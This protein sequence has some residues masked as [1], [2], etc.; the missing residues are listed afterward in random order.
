MRPAPPLN[1]GATLR[2][3]RSLGLLCGSL[4][5]SPAQ[6]AQAE[7]WA[8]DA[9]ERT[10]TGTGTGHGTVRATV[11]EAL[12]LEALR[13]QGSGADQR[14]RYLHAGHGLLDRFW[15]PRQP[16]TLLLAGERA[17]GCGAPLLRHPLAF[18]CPESREIGL[19]LDLR[20]SVRAARGRSDQELLLLELTVLAHEWGHHINRERG[21]GPYRA[22]L[23]LTVRQEE[24]AADW[25]TGIL[26][27]W[28]LS[29]GAIGVDDFTQTANLLFEMGDYERLAAQHHGYPKDRFEALTRGLAS[30]VKPGQQLGGWT[31]DTRDTFSRPLDRAPGSPDPAVRRY[32]V[33]RF[34]IKR[35]TQIA[36]NL[37]GGLLGAASCI[38]GSQEQCLGMAL[39]QGKGRA[40]GRYTA[41]QLR[42][43][44]AQGIFDVSDDD[45][46]AQPLGRD[47][48][49]QAAVLAARD[50]RPNALV[51]NSGG[52]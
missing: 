8:L 30:Q 3:L 20:R 42:L 12:A 11:A 36:T 19:A 13:R 37:L 21:L 49:G 33:R 23:G 47:G 10:G 6:L 2:H 18:Y 31:M 43:D 22:G 28:L 45:F 16:V 50:C 14:R 44:C 9:P 7:P 52:S 26:L 4:L 38:W 34:E 24:L 40:D 41:R 29:T 39:Q 35:G 46:E 1:P 5:L 27:G 32:E 17:S 48:K 25:R 51:F 15:S